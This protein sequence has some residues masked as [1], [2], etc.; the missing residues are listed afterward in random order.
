M[1]VTEHSPLSY[2]RGLSLRELGRDEDATA[3][4]HDLLRFGEDALRQTAQ[5]DYF[6]TSLPN[7]LVFDEDLQARSDADAHLL[8]ALAQHGLGNRDALDPHLREA[9]AFACDDLHA[10]QLAKELA[11]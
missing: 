8:I 9:L 10:T 1:A 6:A 11:G 5:I 4:F 7:L 3:L 2:Y